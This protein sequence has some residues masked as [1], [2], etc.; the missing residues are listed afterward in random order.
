MRLPRADAADEHDG[1]GVGDEAAVEDLQDREP[2]Q[3][4]LC[5]EREGVERLEHREASI[6]DAALDAALPAAGH[7]QMDQLSQVVGR[8]LTLAGGLLGQNGRHCVATVDRH[9]VFVGSD[10]PVRGR[11][12]RAYGVDSRASR[13]RALQLREDVAVF[14]ALR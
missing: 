3:V 1:G 5:V 6:L 4:R 9:S 13:L 11:A 12:R 14:D 10:G 2:V 8:C 7:L